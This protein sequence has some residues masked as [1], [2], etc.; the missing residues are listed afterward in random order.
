MVHTKHQISI[1]YLTLLLQY[2]R[3]SEYKVCIH[4]MQNTRI[5]LFISNSCWCQ[6]TKF[7]DRCRT[8]P[9][10]S[11]S[12]SRA[13]LGNTSNRNLSFSTDRRR[14]SYPADQVLGTS[15][16]PY[17]RHSNGVRVCSE[18]SPGGDLIGPLLVDVPQPDRPSGRTGA[19]GRSV[20]GLRC[21]IPS[22]VITVCRIPTRTHT[23]RHKFDG[24][25]LATSYYHTKR[26]TS[27]VIAIAIAIAI[28]IVAARIINTEIA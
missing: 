28:A 7:V 1:V 20:F 21:L 10:D 25:L 11:R 5:Y 2:R 6:S 23:T 19:K 14:L 8:K 12:G 15:F 26:G 3:T 18:S 9:I 22:V 16:P 17:H 4:P 24:G 13:G 27:A